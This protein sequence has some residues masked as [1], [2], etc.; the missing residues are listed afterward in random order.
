MRLQPTLGEVTSSMQGQ[1]SGCDREM[2][3]VRCQL[4]DMTR[5]CRAVLMSPRGAEGAW[6]FVRYH[7]GQG[8]TGQVTHGTQQR[9]KLFPS[10]S[11][12]NPRYNTEMERQRGRPSSPWH[13]TY[14]KGKE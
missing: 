3:D 5:R 11:S 6:G 2:R 13:A 14:L 4:R 12:L 7:R 10:N 8:L 1:P 9:L